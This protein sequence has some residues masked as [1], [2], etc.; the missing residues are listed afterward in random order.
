MAVSL[1]GIDGLAFSGAGS[2]STHFLF[3]KEFAL[4]S[5]GWDPSST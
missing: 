5:P 4:G 2:A 1:A 3:A